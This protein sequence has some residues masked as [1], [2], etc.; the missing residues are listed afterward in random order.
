MTPA[1]KKPSSGGRKSS[2]AGRKP[3]TGGRNS[4]PRKPSAARAASA[5]R[6]RKTSSPRSVA[7]SRSTASPRSAAPAS[8]GMQAQQAPARSLRVGTLQPAPGAM[9]DRKR[10]GLGT[11]SGLGGTSGRG[12]KGQRARKSGNS[13]RWFE[14]GQMPIQRRL[15]KRGFTNTQRVPHQVVNVVSLSARFSAGDAVNR[16]TLKAKRLIDRS[17]LPV[18]ILGSG[19]VTMALQVSVDRISTSAR[20]KIEAAGGTVTLP[21]VRTHRPRG[22]K[23]TR[24]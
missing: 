22:V 1:K 16:E 13:P 20:Q 5:S 6:G 8:A 9:R 19:D 11:A 7:P 2:S 3:A 18:K 10:R 23:K 17:D 14:G 15:P 4:A 12:H 21:E 24:V